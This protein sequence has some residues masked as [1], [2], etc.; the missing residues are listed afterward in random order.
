[1]TE[2]VTASDDFQVGLK[3]ERENPLEVIQKTI[4]QVKDAYNPL[5]YQ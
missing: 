4:S 3:A 2:F 1:M 5:Q